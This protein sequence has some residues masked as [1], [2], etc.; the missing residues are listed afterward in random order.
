MPPKTPVLDRVWR[1]VGPR[2]YGGVT[3][4]NTTLAYSSAERLAFEAM[5]LPRTLLTT[6]V[7]AARWPRVFDRK[8][9]RRLPPAAT[10][11]AWFVRRIPLYARRAQVMWWPP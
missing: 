6:Q 9:P 5:P 2:R 8:L 10:G 11:D 1:D 4:W 3:F 7:A